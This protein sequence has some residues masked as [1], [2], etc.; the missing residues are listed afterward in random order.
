MNLC[1]QTSWLKQIDSKLNDKIYLGITENK[2]ILGT[3]DTTLSTI[4]T[5]L[6]SIQ[7]MTLS[8]SLTFG[9][10]YAELLTIDTSL[11]GIALNVESIKTDVETLAK[12][13][14]IFTA[15]LTDGSNDYLLRADY[16][17]SPINFYWQ[18]DKNTPV[19]ICEYRFIYP[20]GTEPTQN[21]L[22]H[23]TAWDCNIGAIASVGDS[24][25]VPYITIHDNRDNLHDVNPNAPK[26]QWTSNITWVFDYHFTEAPIEIGISR[27]FGHYIAADINTGLYDDDPIGIV[28]GYYYAS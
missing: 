14:I 3:I 19:Y 13:K 6:T 10:Q 24:F 23:S 18:N 21:Q 9:N 2:T 27:K 26:Q 4:D 16:S 20:E 17:S 25:E 7:S 1:Q 28:S 22:Y 11:T 5:T 15:R 12:K 8:N